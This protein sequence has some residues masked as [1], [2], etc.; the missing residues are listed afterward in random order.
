MVT[1]IKVG[2]IERPF[3]FSWKAIKEA[4]KLAEGLSEFEAIE[5]NIYLGFKYGALKAGKEVDFTQETI[6]EWLDDDL[7]LGARCLQAILD[8]QKKFAGL[9]VDPATRKK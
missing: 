7:T 3:L 8:S 4:D 5:T 9:Q 2:E 6:A 1:L